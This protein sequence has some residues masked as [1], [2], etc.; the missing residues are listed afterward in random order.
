MNTYE[1]YVSIFTSDMVYMNLTQF[2]SVSGKYIKVL[3]AAGLQGNKT[4]AIHGCECL[5]ER[6]TISSQIQVQNKSATVTM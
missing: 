3:K 6:L 5:P 2:Y 4:L 1:S